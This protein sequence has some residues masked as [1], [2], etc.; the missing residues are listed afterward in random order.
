MKKIYFTR[1][2]LTVMNE[3]GLRSGS[4]ETPL[5]ETGRAAAKQ[6]GQSAKGLPIDVIVSSSMGRAVETAEIIAAEI[7]YPLEKI[8]KT[9]LLVERHFGILEGAPY[10]PNQDVDVVEGIELAEMFFARV[11][12]ALELVETLPGQTVL[13]VAHS[14]TG[15]AMRH[16]LNPDIPFAGSGSFPN[17]QIVEMN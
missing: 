9:D 7:G 4:T 3:L 10:Q 2:G 6:A 16:L 14:A 15:R 11:K 8:I 5:T 1:H 12:E 13:I 17:S